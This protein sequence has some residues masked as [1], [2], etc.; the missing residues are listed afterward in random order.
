[1]IRITVLYPKSA[2]SQFDMA[3]YLQK[4][5][6]LV[7]QRLTP[8]GLVGVDLEEGLAGGAPGSPASYYII[9]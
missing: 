9:R 2:G 7:K 3:Y 4:H 5:I 6:P 1:M 8:L